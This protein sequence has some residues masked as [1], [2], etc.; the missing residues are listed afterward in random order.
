[1]EKGS[2]GH[3]PSGHH[4][5]AVAET[6]PPLL[7]KGSRGAKC[8]SQNRKKKKATK[9][10]PHFPERERNAPN[11]KKWLKNKRPYTKYKNILAIWHK[12]I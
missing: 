4:T 9:P 10:T 7:S 5:W 8:L 2:V 12:P 1:M 6:H 11:H 3:V